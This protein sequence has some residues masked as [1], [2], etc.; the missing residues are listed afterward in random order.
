MK[1]CYEEKSTKNHPQASMIDNEVQTSTQLK[2]MKKQNSSY[3]YEIIL[4]KA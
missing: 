3:S 4:I 2:M 1:V